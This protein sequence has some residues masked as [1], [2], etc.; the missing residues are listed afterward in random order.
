[1]K[2]FR[3]INSDEEMHLTNIGSHKFENY[4]KINKN[5][6]DLY[7]SVLKPEV[8][9]PKNSEKK[10]I[11][12][13]EEFLKSLDRRIPYYTIDY[14]NLPLFTKKFV[15]KKEYCNIT[16]IKI[17][18]RIL[19]TIYK[20]FIEKN[21][22]FHY[23]DFKII[24]VVGNLNQKYELFLSKNISKSL[25]KRIIVS[26][27]IFTQIPKDMQ[28]IFNYNKNLDLYASQYKSLKRYEKQKRNG[29]IFYGEPSDSSDFHLE[30][31]ILKQSLKQ[32]IK[33]IG[34]EKNY[35][36]DIKKR[37][38][39]DI[40][41][42]NK[43]ENLTDFKKR[44]LI[45]KEKNSNEL[46]FEYSE[47]LDY[48]ELSEI[49]YNEYKKLIEGTDLGGGDFLAAYNLQQ[50]GYEN[51]NEIKDG[52][53]LIF[54][55]PKELKMKVSFKKGSLAEA[56]RNGDLILEDAYVGGKI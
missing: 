21:C 35:P 29:E 28:E 30:V 50:C 13:M 12:L 19:N 11:D 16:A 26:S 38:I 49:Y 8:N 2:H 55:Q 32:R 15:L 23:Y 17:A 36:I 6:C 14:S 9:I 5:F 54:F 41:K 47:T 52:A 44:V 48:N 27:D 22:C 37:I 7:V 53:K 42:T 25:C 43:I 33:K 40:I 39:D 3:K 56:L 51:P 20:D 46:M 4:N 1:M 31:Q 18:I 45:E 24:I 10:L 34:K